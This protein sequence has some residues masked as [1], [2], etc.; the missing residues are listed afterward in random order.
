MSAAELL[1][2]LSNSP[3]QK[4]N[5]VG[6]SSQEGGQGCSFVVGCNFARCHCMSIL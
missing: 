4:Q 3:S 2:F 6:K 1:L 5:A